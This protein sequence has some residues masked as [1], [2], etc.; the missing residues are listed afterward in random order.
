MAAKRWLQQ[1]KVRPGCGLL[2]LIV[3]VGLTVAVIWAVGWEL[4]A[5][6]YPGA[7]PI[8]RYTN[9][10]FQQ[11]TVRLDNAYRTSDPVREIYDW[12]K[13][14]F[15]LIP[16]GESSEGCLRLRKI[17]HP[18]G[19]QRRTNVWICETPVGQMILISREA[20]LR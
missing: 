7:V 20:S 4:G 14:R 8:S 6:H 3:L 5:I 15:N 10:T 19:F 12:Y 11:G 18:F 2:A 9:Y 13:L 1:Q 16:G 17:I